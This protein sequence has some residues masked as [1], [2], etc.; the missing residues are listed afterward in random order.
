MSL[1][2]TG[3]N[4]KTPDPE[5]EKRDKSVDIINLIT[6]AVN[7]EDANVPSAKDI[8]T[9]QQYNISKS[10]IKRAAPRDTVLPIESHWFDTSDRIVIPKEARGNDNEPPP[11]KYCEGCGRYV[12]VNVR[13]GKIFK[14]LT[15]NGR[16]C[17]QRPALDINDMNKKKCPYC[18]HYIPRNEHGGFVA[19]DVN[20]GADGT[21]RLCKGSIKGH[22]GMK[23]SE[24]YD[25]GVVQARPTT[26]PK[27]RLAMC[28]T[29]GRVYEI[30][31]HGE[32]CSHNDHGRPCT[33]KPIPTSA[34]NKAIHA[35]STADSQ[36]S[37]SF[38]VGRKSS[39][40]P[41]DRIEPMSYKNF[42]Q[43]YQSVE[44]DECFEDEP[45]DYPGE[46]IN[47]RADPMI[48][49]RNNKTKDGIISI[50]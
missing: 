50:W 25:K 24:F 9:T 44:I 16:T 11:V 41:E 12:A 19:H 37:P 46:A 18:G 8:T 48:D 28:D 45:E 2:F 5:P 39:K 27:P 31:P 36:R 1:E 34:L 21:A 26:A 29:C 15:N 43:G 33:G 6:E 13:N 23:P 32:L 22:V 47:D 42:S 40:H 20:G 38:R 14:H 10:P 7:S 49:G 3:T 17:L 30:G 35:L 4:M